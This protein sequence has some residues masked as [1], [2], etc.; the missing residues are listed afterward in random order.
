L[1]EGK[2]RENVPHKYLVEAEA[3]EQATR[4]ARP[5]TERLR[6]LIEREAFRLM[7]E[8]RTEEQIHAQLI[9][10]YG[11]RRRGRPIQ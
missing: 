6:R 4:I 9:S 11:L 1:V 3:R 8:G 7:E 5:L 2:L 10:K